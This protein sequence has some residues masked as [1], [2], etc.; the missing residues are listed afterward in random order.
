M[1]PPFPF[2]NAQTNPS[3]ISS[4]DVVSRVDILLHFL[5]DLIFLGNTFLLAVYLF[6]FVLSQIDLFFL[7]FVSLLLLLEHTR[8]QRHNVCDKNVCQTDGQ[9]ADLPTTHCMVMII[10]HTLWYD[11]LLLL[12]ALILEICVCLLQFSSSGALSVHSLVHFQ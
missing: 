3:H 4:V 11:F 6:I 12:M 10:F 2:T 5:L 9:I 8:S 1:Y 7:F